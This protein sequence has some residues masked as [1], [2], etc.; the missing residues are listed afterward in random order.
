MIH[1]EYLELL[2]LSI[3]FY[4]IPY[5]INNSHYALDEFPSGIIKENKVSFVI[6]EKY[7]RITVTKEVPNTFPEFSSVGN[8]R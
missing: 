3:Q 8:I 4:R 5:L 1:V 2:N 6:R 7:I